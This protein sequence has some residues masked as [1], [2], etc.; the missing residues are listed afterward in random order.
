MPDDVEAAAAVWQG[1][2]PRVVALLDAVL[3]AGVDLEEV[4][5]QSF[6]GARGD[7]GCVPLDPPTA[8]ISIRSTYRVGAWASRTAR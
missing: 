6:P 2:H 4:D 7:V 5:G 3:I 1:G 8:T